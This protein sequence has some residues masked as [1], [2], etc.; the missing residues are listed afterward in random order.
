MADLTTNLNLPK[1]NKF[2]GIV[3]FRKAISDAFDILDAV[4]GKMLTGSKTFDFPSVSA[5]AQTTTTVTVTGAALGDFVTA[6]SVNVDLTGAR[7]FGYVSAADTVTV[8][9]SN[10]TG[11]PVDLASATLAVRVRKA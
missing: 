7:L 5:G 9:L 8:V 4:I 3:P 2:L 10:G 11:G 6:V 1:N